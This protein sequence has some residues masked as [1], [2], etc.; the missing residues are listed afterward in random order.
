L[1]WQEL[2]ILDH[3]ADAGLF[4]LRCMNES[5]RQDEQ[6]QGA[7]ATDAPDTIA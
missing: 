1:P 3:L 4:E 6:E 7:N 2:D 5:K